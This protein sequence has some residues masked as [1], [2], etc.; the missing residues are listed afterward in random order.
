MGCHYAL[1]A[2]KPELLKYKKLGKQIFKRKKKISW[3]NTELSD[4]P[5]HKPL[6]FYL[7]KNKI[8]I[9]TGEGLSLRKTSSK[10]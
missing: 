5:S 9:L 8:N 7:K 4:V 2:Y 6:H 10:I 3:S 1:K